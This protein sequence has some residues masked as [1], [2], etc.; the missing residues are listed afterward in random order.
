M[1]GDPS[2]G[3][4]CLN[5][6]LRATVCHPDNRIQPETGGVAR[7]PHGSVLQLWPYQTL[8]TAHLG[9]GVNPTPA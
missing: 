9:A 1:A 4:D 7:G 2:R 8:W 5:D 6:A 3:S